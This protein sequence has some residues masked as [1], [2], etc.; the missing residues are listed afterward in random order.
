MI[1]SLCCLALLAGAAVPT[2]ADEL[3]EARAAAARV[4][5]LEY[6]DL[7]L[8]PEQRRRVMAALVEEQLAGQR[9]LAQ[10]DERAAPLL[11]RLPARPAPS[12]S[13]E[14]ARLRR[15][16]EQAELA[17]RDFGRFLRGRSRPDAEELRRFGLDPQRYAA[18]NLSAEQRERF[19]AVTAEA[20][21]QVDDAYVRQDREDKPWE[22]DAWR[23]FALRM[24]EA[25]RPRIA[26]FLDEEQRVTFDELNRAWDAKV[27]DR[28]KRWLAG[29][30]EVARAELPEPPKPAERAAEM[31]VG[32]E[33]TLGLKGNPAQL[34][35]LRARLRALLEHQVRWGLELER[36]TAALRAAA[37]KG[38][39][40]TGDLLERL[41]AAR[42]AAESKEAALAAA[43][44]RLLDGR[45]RALLVVRGLLR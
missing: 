17:I 36:R 16:R 1:R 4:F 6:H 37:D 26:A 39:P 12:A 33:R 44:A 10:R 43:L 27:A 2:L 21:V 14:L 22:Y 31:A 20:I 40:E 23:A 32:I 24:R 28:Y 42:T 11:G 38:A 41:R 8:S 13:E 5:A 29:R 15:Q 25:L 19:A 45:Q 34:E 3:A 30:G 18:L 9:A 7:E 35:A